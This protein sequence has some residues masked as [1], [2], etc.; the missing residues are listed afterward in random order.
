MTDSFRRVPYAPDPNAEPYHAA[1]SHAQSKGSNHPAK[2]AWWYV[3]NYAGKLNVPD[4]WQRAAEE[5]KAT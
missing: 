3:D 2:F 5:V 4:A 1:H